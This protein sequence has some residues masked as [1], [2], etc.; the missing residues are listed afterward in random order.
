MK[1]LSGILI[2]PFKK[3]ITYHTFEYDGDHRALYGVLDCDLFDIVTLT[4]GDEDEGDTVLMFVDDE[5]LY[6]EDQRF[7]SLAVMPKNPF[8][9]KTFIIKEDKLG[10]LISMQPHMVGT[11][12]M[13]VH[14]LGDAQELEEAIQRGS[15]ARPYSAFGTFGVGEDMFAEP[16]NMTKTWEWYPPTPKKEKE[17]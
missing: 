9:G 3:E 16:K 4:R 1:T 2:D 6:K 14:W 8:A 13:M 12:K 5:G 11:I 15:I 17:V 10:D 7:F